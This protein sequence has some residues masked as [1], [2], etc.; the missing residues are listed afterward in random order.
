MA[1]NKKVTRNRVIVA[2]VIF[3]CVFIFTE[4]FPV[5][6]YVGS[7]LNALYLEFAL[8]L[9]PY[10]LAGY[11]VLYKAARNIG[12]G[13]VFDENFL[14]SVATIGAFALV[15]FPGSDPHMAEGAAV[16]LFIR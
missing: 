4:F 3:A 13:Q 16:M 15:L 7:E 8:F 14:M 12:H 1:K 11:D 10:L 9:I 2:L 5:A 6:T